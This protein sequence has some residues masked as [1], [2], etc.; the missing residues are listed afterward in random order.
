MFY[1]TDLKCCFEYDFI[2]FGM[3]CQ[4]FEP[5]NIIVDFPKFVWRECGS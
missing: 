5:S 3:S 4:I 2:S 1:K